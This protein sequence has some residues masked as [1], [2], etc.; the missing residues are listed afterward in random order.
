MPHTDDVVVM[1]PE[2]DICRVQHSKEREPPRDAVN[3]H[4]LPSIEELIDD[5][6]EKQE[7][8]EGPSNF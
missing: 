3:D 2:R 5:G 6:S 4:L 1:S 8:D 7:M